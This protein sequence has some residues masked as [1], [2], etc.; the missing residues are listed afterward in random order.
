M[1]EFRDSLLNLVLLV[2]SCFLAE[3]AVK[4]PLEVFDIVGQRADCE[5]KGVVV[6]F[7]NPTSQA[8]FL[9]RSFGTCPQRFHAPPL[10]LLDAAWLHHN[11]RGMDTDSSF[12]ANKRTTLFEPI[13]LFVG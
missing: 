12:M 1:G 2:W 8:S 4:I 5:I 3:T 13:A 6:P 9:G 10:R 11:I 7:H